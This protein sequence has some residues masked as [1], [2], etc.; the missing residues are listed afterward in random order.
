M[1]FTV[2]VRGAGLN[3]AESR[4]EQLGSN[5]HTFLT[6]RFDRTRSGERIHFCSALTLLGRA[7]GDDAEAGASYLELAELVARTGANPRKDAKRAVVT[8]RVPRARGQHRRPPPEPRLPPDAEGLD[9]LAR[10]SIS[11]RTRPPRRSSLNIDEVDN[12]LDLDIV[13]RVAKDFLVARDAVE[14]RIDTTR[15]VVA[16]WKSEAKAIGISRDEQERM[17][18]AFEA[19]RL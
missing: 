1:S 7:D 6:R 17:A 5:Q 14:T 10:V 8:H 11:I 3:V 2:W 16:R 12:R 4:V 13:R 19:S 18:S 9:A 15:T